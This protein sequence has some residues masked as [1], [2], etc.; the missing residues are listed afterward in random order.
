MNRN[1]IMGDLV[2]GPCAIWVDLVSKKQ[3]IFGDNFTCSSHIIEHVK[4][5]TFQCAVELKYCNGSYFH[6]WDSQPW[7]VYNSMFVIKGFFYSYIRPS[8]WS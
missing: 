6:I 8:F 5:K 7:N 4:R 2:I 1:K 3:S